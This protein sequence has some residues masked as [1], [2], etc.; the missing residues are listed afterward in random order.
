[1]PPDASSAR[2]A[3]SSIDHQV[4]GAAAPTLGAC[5]SAASAALSK[6]GAGSHLSGG[7]WPPSLSSSSS[8]SED[9]YSDVTGGESPS[10]SR[11]RNSS[12]LCSRRSRRRIPRSF[13]RAAHSY[14]RRCAARARSGSGCGQVRPRNVPGHPLL[15]R[16][17]CQSRIGTWRKNKGKGEESTHRRTVGKHNE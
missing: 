8:S 7:A 5:S 9:E 3:A 17:R 14:S 11:S 1:V 4:V 15:G 10:C 12:Y 2:A 6:G 16:T 13:L